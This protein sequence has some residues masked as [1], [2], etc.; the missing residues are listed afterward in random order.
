MRVAVSDLVAYCYCQRKPWLS[1]TV[2]VKQNRVDLS[3]GLKFQV[4]GSIINLLQS[5]TDLNSTTD[6]M[7]KAIQKI[8]GE[9]VGTEVFLTRENL[10]GKIDVIRKTQDGYIVQEEK[11]SDPPESKGW[12]GEVYPSDKLQVNAYAFLMEES[13][14]TPLSYGIV[15]YNDLKPRKV[16]PEPAQ[17]KEILQKLTRLLESDRLPDGCNNDN[18]CRSCGYYA[19]CQVLPRKGGRPTASEIKALPEI[20]ETGRFWIPAKESINVKVNSV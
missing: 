20:L 3:P 12:R 5:A 17:A 6:I 4:S 1:K 13:R 8:P 19:L 9:I 10:C 16:K 7:V 18:M 2:G 14:Y 15:L 11:F